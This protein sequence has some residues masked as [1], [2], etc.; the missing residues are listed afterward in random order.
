M[1]TCTTVSFLGL[2]NGLLDLVITIV[3]YGNN[4]DYHLYPL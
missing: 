3:V 2:E 1:E 4:Q